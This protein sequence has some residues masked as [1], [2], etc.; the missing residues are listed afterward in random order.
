MEERKLS[1]KCNDDPTLVEDKDGKLAKELAKIYKDIQFNLGFCYEQLTKGELTE[2]MKETHL[3]LTESYVLSFLKKM[4]YEGILEREQN[5]RLSEI[6]SLN[7]ENRE[8]RKQLGEKVTN[9]D[10]REKIKNICSN[11]KRWWNIEGFGHVS[12]MSFREYGTLTVKLSGNISRSYYEDEERTEE[13]KIKYL[14]E[15]GFSID[16]EKYVIFNDSNINLLK[17]LLTEKY[18]SAKIWKIESHDRLTSMA[19][20]DIEIIIKNLNDLESC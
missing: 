19:I 10:F 4:G 9:E 2:G 16:N 3:S 17:K 13:E 6:R 12:E 14:E 18:P 8:L 5:E 20:W 7:D 1:F 11:F 15:L